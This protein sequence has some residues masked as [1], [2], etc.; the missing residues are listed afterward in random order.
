LAVEF[1]SKI[2]ANEVSMAALQGHFVRDTQTALE[3][4]ARIPELLQVTKPTLVETRGIYEHLH[5]IGLEKYAS[6]FEDNGIL[7]AT[8]LVGKSLADVS[9]MAVELQFN[10]REC[11]LLEKL[12]KEDSEFMANTYGFALLATVRE[13]FL[14]TYP[15]SYEGE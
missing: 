2:P 11:S 3:C 15:T 10:P 12:I 4:V 8:D 6:I 9:L 1:A 14:A 7:S 13:M 5:R